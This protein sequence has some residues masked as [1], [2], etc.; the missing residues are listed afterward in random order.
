M[1]ELVIES[2][3]TLRRNVLRT[4]L[5]MIGVILGV[6]A[7]VAIMSMGTSAYSTVQKTFI[8]S[9]FS[10]LTLS[11]TSNSAPPLTKNTINYLESQ[12][13]NG[14]A[15]Y[16][17]SLS[18]YTQATDRLSNEFDTV[19]VGASEDEVSTANLEILSGTFFTK[20]DD[21]NRSQVVVIDN[22]L[23]NEFFYS[24]QEAIGQ[25]IRLDGK[26]YKIIGI[27]RT[28]EPF[29]KKRARVY[30]PFNTLLGHVP[31]KKGFNSI[32]I[33][34]DERA[35]AEAVQLQIKSVI[36]QQRGLIN[37][38]HLDFE[39]SNPR[40]ELAQIQQF[41][42]IF[43]LIM[44]LIA[45]ISLVVGGVGIMNIMLVTVTERTK[46]IGLMKAL[47]AQ[48][49]DIVLQFLIESVVLTVFGGAIGVV[50]GILIA[51]AAV[52]AINMFNF[53]P[54]FVFRIN[55]I[56]IVVSFVISVLI[57][58]VFGAYPAKKAAKLDPVDALRR[59]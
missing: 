42:T 2:L 52:Q 35:D 16:K 49:E 3:A 44:S 28:D 34:V 11:N 29:N 26:S 48:E 6:G 14:V 15:K 58:L 38:D 37:E 13:I 25:K 18:I 51:F 8:E 45:A 33:L 22:K 53:T 55:Y 5:T 4:I 36:M 39:V 19:V 30:V 10:A 21:L 24:Y 23:S 1:F 43:S 41:F 9:G 54:D 7:V 59:E 32:S 56:S 40:S 50:L 46:E 47:G 31:G 20:F 17:S 57:G 12:N 27:Y